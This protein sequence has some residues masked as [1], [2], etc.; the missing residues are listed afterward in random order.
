MAFVPNP[1][2]PDWVR[3]FNEI[4]DTMK[5]TKRT[6]SITSSERDKLRRRMDRLIDMIMTEKGMRRANGMTDEDPHI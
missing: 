3:E 6:K 1:N 2:L 5:A 4:R